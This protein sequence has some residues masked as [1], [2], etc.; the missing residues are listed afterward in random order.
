[1][2]VDQ[3][4]NLFIYDWPCIGSVALMIYFTFREVLY[5]I[6]IRFGCLQLPWQKNRCTQVT[7]QFDCIRISAWLALTEAAEHISGKKSTHV[8]TVSALCQSMESEVITQPIK[9]RILINHVPNEQNNYS[10]KGHTNQRQARTSKSG[11]QGHLPTY[12]W[13]K[14]LACCNSTHFSMVQIFIFFSFIA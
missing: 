10:W 13:G 9:P 2:L 12:F 1:M 11:A 7:M 5:A 14:Q 6:T 8:L 4:K 3:C